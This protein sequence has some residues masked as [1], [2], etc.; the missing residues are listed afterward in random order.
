[1]SCYY[2]IALFL[3]GC[4][5][6]HQAGRPA[7]VEASIAFY[8]VENLFDTVDDP[9]K[10]DEEFLP[11]SA[12]KWND[13]RYS[14][15]LARLAQVVAA[16]GFPDLVGLAEIEN[17]S[18]L[19]DFCLKTNLAQHG[20]WFVHFESPDVRGIDVA[21]LYKRTRF[22]VLDSSA[23]SIDFPVELIADQ[24]NYTTRDLLFVKGLLQGK[25][26]LNL[27]V[28]HLPSR[29]GGVKESEPKRVFVA[30]Q[31]RM[32][33]NELFAKNPKANI[34]LM[35]D[36]ND[37]PFDKSISQTI[38]AQPMP[39]EP[40]FTALYNCFY[41]QR[42]EQKGTYN[43]RGNWNQLDQIILSGNLVRK[44]S[45]LHFLTAT[46]FEQDWMMYEDDKFGKAPSRTFGGDRY[47]G[48]YSDHL[49]VVVEL[50]H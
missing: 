46:N 42:G 23:I 14:T 1:M 29:T 21:L 16:M 10:Q 15:K 25:D 20:Y 18:V 19:R 47:F 44:K 7:S 41:K 49:P 45:K 24:P 37:E 31:A 17:D 43:Y 34:V 12:K 9:Q 6:F 3:S 28:A 11:N 38:G 33:V 30:A 40:G 35:G 8:N 13:D 32:K 26:T 2:L 50:G 27:L 36:F 5:V 48:G 39:A 4:A 22:Q